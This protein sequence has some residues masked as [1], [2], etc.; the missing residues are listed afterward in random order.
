MNKA[1]IIVL[2]IVL[3]AGV[4]T[5]CW[6]QQSKVY[7]GNL[8]IF[9]LHEKP[10]SVLKESK[11]PLM[12]KYIV[13]FITDS[14]SRIKDFYLCMGSGNDTAD[15]VS[16]KITIVSKNGK[17]YSHGGDRDIPVEGYQISVT[18]TMK[19]TDM[20]RLSQY[21]VYAEDVNG[22]KCQQL[23]SRGSK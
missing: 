5:K 6:G 2:F 12:A 4:V 15:I 20:A 17:L 13:S 14:P 3:A 23:K 10:D 8:H 11:N 16:K 1:N 21:S 18:L 22:R 9:P 7:V 19:R